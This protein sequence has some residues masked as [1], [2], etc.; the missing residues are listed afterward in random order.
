[1]KE[2]ASRLMDLAETHIRE[3]GYGGFSFRDLAAQIGIKSASVHHHFPT[4]AIMVSAVARRYG[5]RFF[6]KVTAKPGERS[7][8]AIDSYKNA[9]REGF[10]EDGLMCLYGVLGTEAGALTE[11]VSE[12]IVGFFQRC[13]DDLSSRIGGPDAKVKAFHVM[14]TLEGGIMLARAYGDIEAFDQA[15]AGLVGE[16]P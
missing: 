3:S 11:D 1:M 4:K 13:I 2:T 9:F 16:E 10:L 5:E 14:A 12:Q 6:A 7:H 8:D 15:V